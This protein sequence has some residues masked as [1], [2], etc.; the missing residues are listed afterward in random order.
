MYLFV[1]FYKMATRRD[2][3]RCRKTKLILFTSPGESLMHHESEGMPGQR[4]PPSRWEVERE[5]KEP[6]ASALL[7][8]RVENTSKRH[9]G[10]S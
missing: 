5:N 2:T 1:F 10:I 6:W 8:V 7:E 3:E 9:E 4:A